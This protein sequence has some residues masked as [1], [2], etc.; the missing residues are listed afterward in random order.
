MPEHPAIDNRREIHLCGETAAVLLIGQKIDRQRQPTAGQHGHETVVAKRTDKAVERHGGE[1]IE[2]G[3]QLQTETAVCGQQ[4]IPGDLWTHLAV[5]QDKMRQD[6]E[7]RTTRGALDPPDGDATQA[8]TG[9][10]RVARQASTA[11][12]GRLVCQLKAKGQEKGEDA[13]DKGLAITKQLKV[14]RFVLEID[15]FHRI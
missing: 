11:V 1:V 3:A 10:M 12:T 14:G 8:D 9:I 7:H 5:A 13:F 4:G 15:T 2:H 6:G